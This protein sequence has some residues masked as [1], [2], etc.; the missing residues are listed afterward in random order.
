MSPP[1]APP[2]PPWQK[3]RVPIYK[4]APFT[5]RKAEKVAYS[6]NKLQG[7]GVSQA[8][9]HTLTLP[10]H[11]VPLLEWRKTQH[12]FPFCSIRS[13]PRPISLSGSQR[14]LHTLI[15]FIPT[16][17]L[18][19]TLLRNWKKWIEPNWYQKNELNSGFGFFF[20][21]LNQDDRIT[22]RAHIMQAMGTHEWFFTLPISKWHLNS[23]TLTQT[24]N[25]NTHFHCFLKQFQWK[26][27]FE[28]GALKKVINNLLFF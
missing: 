18:Q 19:R 20:F 6:L 16:I 23:N 21:P 7:E 4:H 27:R 2:Q 15:S 12:L 26:Y 3:C 28:S 24:K 11:P 25:K 5:Q 10:I 14:Q 22:Q 13:S 9:L 17:Y 8:A 1:P